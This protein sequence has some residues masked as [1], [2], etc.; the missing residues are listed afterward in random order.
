MHRSA[1]FKQNIFAALRLKDAHG[2]F[3]KQAGKRHAH[4]FAVLQLI[5]ASGLGYGV[6]ASA[7]P[8]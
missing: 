7:N 1:P 4:T 3:G 5:A 2:Q 6:M 8:A